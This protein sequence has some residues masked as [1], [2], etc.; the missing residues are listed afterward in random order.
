VCTVL[1]HHMCTTQG[2]VPHSEAC[3]ELSGTGPKVERLSSRPFRL[4][5]LA[6]PVTPGAGGRPV[7]VGHVALDV[8]RLAALPF[9]PLP[10]PTRRVAVSFR[11]RNVCMG[12][13]TI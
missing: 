1:Q 12:E 6:I 11:N 10:P 7:V 5:N 4:R 3:G 9:L 2:N 8:C 13:N